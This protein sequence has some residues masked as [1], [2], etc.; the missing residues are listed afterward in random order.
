MARILSPLPGTF[1]RA[2]APGEPPF[3]ADG[4]SVAVGDVIGLIEVMGLAVLPARLK[5]ELTAV[6]Q[7]LVEGGDLHG[8]ERT[9]K[10]AHWAEGFRASYTI[11][12]ENAMEIVLAETGRVFAKVLE[13]AGVYSRTDEGRAAFLQFIEQV[14]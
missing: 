9:A 10:H 5:E 3:K 11:T 4:D 6:A 1:Y 2:T 8:D 12:A 7:L 14:R 13:H